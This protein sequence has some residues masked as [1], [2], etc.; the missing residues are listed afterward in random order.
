MSRQNVPF[1]TDLARAEPTRST[2]P[3][4]PGRDKILCLLLGMVLIGDT[5]G[6]SCVLPA[7]ATIDEAVLLS[8][9]RQMHSEGHPGRPTRPFTRA[10]PPT[11]IGSARA[12]WHPPSPS[13]MNQKRQWGLVRAGYRPEVTLSTLGRYL[14]GIPPS[15][16]NS[17]N[18]NMR[19]QCRECR[20]MTNVENRRCDACGCA[21]AE[22]SPLRH[23]KATWKTW[24]VAFAFGL[25]AAVI[26]QA[27]HV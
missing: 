8:M 12:A 18:R 5:D 2:G 25:L 11:W 23:H 13:A 3:V 26:R 14:W 17:E 7:E 24:I 9:P 4:R 16:V 10:T 19:K 15:C 27:L 1:G 21:V 20:T 6:D 22:A